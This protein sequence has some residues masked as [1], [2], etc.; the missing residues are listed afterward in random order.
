MDKG[1]KCLPNKWQMERMIMKLQ[2][3]LCEN[4]QKQM[5]STL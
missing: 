2:V 4:E 3:M 1:D 5:S